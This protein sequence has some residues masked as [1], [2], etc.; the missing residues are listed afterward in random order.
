MHVHV[1]DGNARIVDD[2]FGEVILNGKP[3][4][5]A[6]LIAATIERTII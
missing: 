1:H 2:T 4:E 3:L 5:R 6:A